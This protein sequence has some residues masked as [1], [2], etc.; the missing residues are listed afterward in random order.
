MSHYWIN[1]RGDLYDLSSPRVMGIVNIT[2]DSFFVGSRYTNVEELTAAIERMLSEGVDMIDV[3]AF[4]SRPGALPVSEDE[5]KT[6]LG[7]ALEAIRN[8][9]PDIILSIDTCRASIAEWAVTTFGID[10]IND[11]SGGRA[12]KDM[13]ATIARLQVPYIMMHMRGTPADMQN[14]AK[15]KN[16][17]QEVIYE[18]SECL[19]H[20]RYAGI[21]DIILDPGFGFAKTLEQ[22]Y[23]LMANLEALKIMNLPI[24]VGISRK[25]MIY[26]LL[27]IQPDQALNGTTA[28]HMIALMKGANILRVHDVWAA[29]EAIRLFNAIKN[30]KSMNHEE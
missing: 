13:Y 21:N 24:L 19:Y 15:Y 5:E 27:N 14:H 4:S 17:T 10:L 28:L 3:G 25:S 9:F 30:A 8:R 6:R 1:I 12:D 2:P 22:N 18:L 7:K 26:K 23:E 29:R 11:I 20:A 16:V